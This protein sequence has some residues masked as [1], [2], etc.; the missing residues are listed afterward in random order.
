[1]QSDPYPLAKAIA[2]CAL[3]RRESRG[4]HLRADFPGIDHALD[5]IHLVLAANG[6]IRSE[7]WL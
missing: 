3:E 2:T 7:E 5:R 6:E 1:L 4:G